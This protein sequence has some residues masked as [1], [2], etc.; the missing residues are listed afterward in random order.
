MERQ[1][2][3][4]IVLVVDDAPDYL[5]G[6][7]ILLEQNG[8]DA[9]TAESGSEALKILK[10]VTPDIIVTDL[11]MPGMD[12]VELCN[13]IKADPRLS[14]IPVLL[15]SAVAHHQPPSGCFDAFLEK[16]G[17]YELFDD[18]ESWMSRRH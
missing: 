8:L 11:M 2:A 7:S 18:V 16:R 1:S 4:K 12:G 5:V 15:V 17:F 13:R 3:R 6:F 14:D 9:V 10:H